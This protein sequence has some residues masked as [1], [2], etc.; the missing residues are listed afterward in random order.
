MKQT[1][2]SISEFYIAPIKSIQL[3]SVT[4]N[5]ESIQFKHAQ[6]LKIIFK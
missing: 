4:Y 5:F 1:I 6:L 2:L 3:R